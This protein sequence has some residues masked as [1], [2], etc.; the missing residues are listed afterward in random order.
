MNNTKMANKEN[1]SS[2]RKDKNNML[3]K[4]E[5][6]F[7][8][9][10]DYNVEELVKDLTKCI[11]ECE[12][13]QKLED[14]AK[15][16]LLTEVIREAIV[17]SE[18][19]VATYSML[20]DY[21]VVSV[22]GN[23]L[24]NENWLLGEIY[25]DNRLSASDKGFLLIEEPVNNLLELRNYVTTEYI[26]FMEVLQEYYADIVYFYA[27]PLDMYSNMLLKNIKT[28]EFEDF[29]MLLCECVYMIKTI[30]DYE[31]FDVKSYVLD[32]IN[33]ENIEHIDQWMFISEIAVM[34][35]DELFSDE[36]NQRV[37]DLYNKTDIE[38]VKDEIGQWIDVA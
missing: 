26:N 27:L 12:E 17:N 35:G 25:N 11:E 34:H 31:I 3:K 37:V 21:R 32:D 15:V 19:P 20:L 33:E 7:M 28:E 6:L 13:Y 18:D 29:K 5:E 2:K 16:E 38:E 10:E 14:S 24:G 36:I 23:V 30:L 4:I 8:N 9:A 1:T 22:I